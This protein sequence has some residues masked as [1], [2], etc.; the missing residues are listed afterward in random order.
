MSQRVRVIRMGNKI[1]R[2]E[3]D[4]SKEDLKALELLSEQCPNVVI[5][6]EWFECDC[7]DRIQSHE[8]FPKAELIK[9]MSC[10]LN[11]RF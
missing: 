4:E 2:Y 11:H 3:G 8:T 6:L 7:L 10:P 5:Q 1:T 9:I